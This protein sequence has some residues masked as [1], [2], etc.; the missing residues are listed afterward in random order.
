MA[1]NLQVQV[2]GGAVQS[3]KTANTVADLASQVGARGYVATV[4]GETADADQ[5]LNDYEYVAFAKPVKAG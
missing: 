3:G 1:K 2:S 4:N 5:K